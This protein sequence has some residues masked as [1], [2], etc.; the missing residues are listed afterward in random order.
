MT[1]TWVH[2]YRLASFI[3]VSVLSVFVMPSAPNAPTP[4]VSE[5]NMITPTEGYNL[6]LLNSYEDGL[7][8]RCMY[9]VTLKAVKGTTEE[10]VLTFSADEPDFEVVRQRAIK[11]EWVLI[12]DYPYGLYLPCGKEREIRETFNF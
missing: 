5:S 7:K 9:T 6:E 10:V 2:P 12:L 1:F 11:R 3:A 8:V 4:S